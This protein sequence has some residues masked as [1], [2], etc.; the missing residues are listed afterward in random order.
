[1]PFL[2]QIIVVLVV[3]GLLY[4]ILTLIPLPAPFPLLVRQH[5][6]VGYV[7]RCHLL[8]PKTQQRPFRDAAG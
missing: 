5:E 8:S 2:F 1:M 3:C 7:K 6:T 4:W